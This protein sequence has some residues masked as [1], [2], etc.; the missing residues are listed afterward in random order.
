MY[1]LK[2]GVS[3]IGQVFF[4]IEVNNQ[5]YIWEVLD[6]DDGVVCFWGKWPDEWNPMCPT[7]DSTRLAFLLYEGRDLE[8]SIRTC[9]KPEFV[10]ECGL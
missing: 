2:Q 10:A 6:F 7:H 1:K 4:T 3:T 9:G 8:E 5:V